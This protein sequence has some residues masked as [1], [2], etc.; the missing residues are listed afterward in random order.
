MKKKLNFGEFRQDESKINKVSSNS[1]FIG[2]V[3]HSQTYKLWTYTT[4]M[5][6]KHSTKKKKKYVF[7]TNNLI[8]LKKKI[9]GGI[10]WK[11]WIII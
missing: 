4:N 3:S 9:I 6:Q 7:F 2:S 10:K 5:M 8:E 1:A 11:C